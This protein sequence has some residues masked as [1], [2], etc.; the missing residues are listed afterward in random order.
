MVQRHCVRHVL[1]AEPVLP[2]SKAKVDVFVIGEIR[3]V[4]YAQVEPVRPRYREERAGH[5]CDLAGKYMAVAV[6]AEPTGRCDSGEGDWIARC[7]HDVRAVGQPD[8]P[9]GQA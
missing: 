7:I 5:G 3:L 1:D 2:G 6:L 8:T 4:E 9:C